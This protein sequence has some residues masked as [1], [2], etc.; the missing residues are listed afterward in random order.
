MK[1]SIR[2]SNDYHL[3]RYW[4]LL[5][6]NNSV[7]SAPRIVRYI[8]Y[9]FCFLWRA[10]LQDDYWRGDI[11]QCWQLGQAPTFPLCEFPSEEIE[12]FHLGEMD[13]IDM[14]LLWVSPKCGLDWKLGGYLWEVA[15]RAVPE[16]LL[17]AGK[18]SSRKIRRE[19]ILLL[20]KVQL[21]SILPV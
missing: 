8:I 1:D 18:I 19:I 17:Q 7:L 13:A 3:F 5:A 6:G 12:T 10:R 20:E 16:R 2:A 21:E 14:R 4:P 11:F 9:C 15:V